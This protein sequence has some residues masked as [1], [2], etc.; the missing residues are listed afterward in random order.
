[1]LV[2]YIGEITNMNQQCDIIWVSEDERY[3]V[4]AFSMWKLWSRDSDFG[5][6]CFQPSK[7]RDEAIEIED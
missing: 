5:V 1:M 2:M 7:L 3:P 4:I 6:P